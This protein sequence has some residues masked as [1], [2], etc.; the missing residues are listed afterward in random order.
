MNVKVDPEPDAYE[1]PFWVT[2][3]EK[4][5]ELPE[6]GP[7]TVPVR[8]IGIPC[9]GKAGAPLMATWSMFSVRLLALKTGSRNRPLARLGP[10]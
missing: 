4:L 3:Q 10:L 5:N 7:V 2:V 9:K 1:L 6:L 8:G